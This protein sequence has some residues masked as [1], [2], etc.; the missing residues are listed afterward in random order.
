MIHEEN[1]FPSEGISGTSPDS[2][3][4]NTPS[5]R[6]LPPM[7]DMNNFLPPPQVDLPQDAFVPP[8]QA[9]AFQDE[10]VPPPQVE[11]FQ[12]KFVPP[13]QVEES[14]DESVPPPQV[15]ESQDELVPP[16]QAVAFQVELPPLAPPDE[17]IEEG[18]IEGEGGEISKDEKSDKD[19]LYERKSK[20]IEKARIKS[21]K[22]ESDKGKSIFKFISILLAIGFILTSVSTVVLYFREDTDKDTS[23]LSV[24]SDNDG[25]TDLKE[26]EIGTSPTKKDTDGMDLSFGNHEALIEA[27]KRIGTRTGWLGDTF[28][29]GSKRAGEI[30]GKGAE[31]YANHI[32][33]LELPG[34]DLRTLKTAALGFSVSYRGACHLRSGAYSPDVKGKVDRFKIEKGRGK[35]IMDGEDLYNVVDSL[36]LCKFSRGVMYDGLKDMAKYFTL[37][38]GIEMTPEELILAGERINNLARVINIR[39]GKGTRAN[40]TL[41][42]KIMNFPVPDEG[43]AKGAVVNQKEFDLGLDDYYEVRGWTK[44]GIPTPEKLK[45]LGL[46]DLVSIVEKKL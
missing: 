9:E 31:K 39:E 17:I 40:D 35:L 16:P 46:D 14:Q 30:I 25:L 20:R 32:K 42:W 22:R 29:E 8:P 2:P 11:A 10:L 21:Q 23:V 7:P 44:N 6:S 12:D 13:P 24:D 4:T 37:A 5:I 43:I 18:G 41:P 26:K 28:A 38:T 3:E 36:I 33:G 34:Y 45:E 1:A 19:Q 15:E 27:I